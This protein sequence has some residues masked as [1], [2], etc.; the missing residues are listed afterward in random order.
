MPRAGVR[1]HPASQGLYLSRFGA[2]TAPAGPSAL[3]AT[4]PPPLEGPRGKSVPQ[5]L[6]RLRVCGIHITLRLL[7]LRTLP[8]PSPL[9]PIS[10]SLQNIKYP[11][12]P[13]WQER[14]PQH[15]HTVPRRS[16]TVC[17]RIAYATT[18]S[19]TAPNTT[20]PTAAPTGGGTALPTSR[21]LFD[22]ALPVSARTIL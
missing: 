14:H 22:A 15:P 9:Y 3:I 5:I 1:R 17:T 20:R 18:Q 7:P 21:Y 19:A 13:V 12:D 2:I 10:K 11:V 8:P 16:P 4:A 6:S